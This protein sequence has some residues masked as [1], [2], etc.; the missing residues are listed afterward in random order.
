MAF[1]NPYLY[2]Q[3]PYMAQYQAQPQNQQPVQQ[4]QNGGLVTVRS[5][6]EARNY[7]VALGTSVT[8]KHET[9]PYCFTKTMGF[10]QF[11]APKFEKYRLVKEEGEPAAEVKEAIPYAT[12]DDLSAVIGVV[13][14]FDEVIGSIRSDIEAMKGDLYGIAGKKKASKKAVEVTDDDE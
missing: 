5:E 6:E 8:F 2:Y 12:K 13:K 14:G 3:N 1:N 4:I 10:S 11:E 9:A 7:P